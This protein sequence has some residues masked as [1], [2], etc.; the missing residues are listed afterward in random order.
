M[1]F[2]AEN[3]SDHIRKCC[4]GGKHLASVEGKC[5]GHYKEEN[6]LANIAPLWRGLCYSTYD[7]CCSKE[8]ER[9]DCDAG[10][11]AAINSR[12]CEEKS[13]TILRE[14]PS[15]TDC[16]RSCQIGLA[17]KA[18]GNDCNDTLFN[19]F[20]SNISY[21]LCCLG[22]GGMVETDAHQKDN[23]EPRIGNTDSGNGAGDNPSAHSD[24]DPSTDRNQSSTS[25][26]R[27]NDAF[28]GL[29]RIVGNIAL[30]NVS[31][32]DDGTIVLQANDGEFIT[33]HF[34]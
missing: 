18:S 25:L 1:S 34:L 24:E 9:Q 14:G 16:C 31:I 12:S 2:N 23:E 30:Q 8:L 20:V 7:V 27:D 6:V 15:Y 19:D 3:I 28:D 5:G 26:T 10:R 33:F 11:L 29:S 17:V 13:A 22:D 21:Q 32:S 4:N